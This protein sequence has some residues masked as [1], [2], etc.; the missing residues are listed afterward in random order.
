MQNIILNCIDV[1]V[2]SKYDLFPINDVEIGK[3]EK[4]FKE[5]LDDCDIPYHHTSGDVDEFVISCSF[6]DF[7][8]NV[9]VLPIADTNTEDLHLVDMV[10]AASNIDSALY[11]SCRPNEYQYYLGWLNHFI[12]NNYAY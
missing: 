5:Y 6:E 3:L 12:R 11:N 2:L 7:M 9:V 8:E 4:V 1:D 10:D